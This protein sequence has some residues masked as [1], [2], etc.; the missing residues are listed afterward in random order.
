MVPKRTKSG[1]YLVCPACGRR[2]KLK[3]RIKLTERKK[4]GRITVIEKNVIN[5]PVVRKICPKCGYTKAYYQVTQGR[6]EEAASA[7]LFI[8]KR[9]GYKWKE[10]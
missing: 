9:C 7:E 2:K 4:K 1:A 8:C 5:L 10:E 3:R 6:S